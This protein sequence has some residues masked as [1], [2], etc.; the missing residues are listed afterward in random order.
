MG[1]ETNENKRHKER[2][3]SWE[4]MEKKVNELRKH[5]NIL[6]RDKRGEMREEGEKGFIMLLRN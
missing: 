1:L 3:P 5:L 6:E 4:R 2:E